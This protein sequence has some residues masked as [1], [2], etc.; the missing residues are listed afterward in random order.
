MKMRCPLALGAF[1]SSFV[2]EKAKKKKKK[3]NTKQMS[4]VNCDALDDKRN[5]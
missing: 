4:T 1:I 2:E 3:K 5:Y